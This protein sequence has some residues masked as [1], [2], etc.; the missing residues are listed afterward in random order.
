MKHLIEIPLANDETVIVE[1]DGAE[2][3]AQPI[4]TRRGVREFVEEQIVER[5]GQ[6][7]EAALD[8]VRPAAAAIIEKLQDLSRAP[9]E[10]G[11]E[12]GIKF[13]AKGNAFIT[14]ADT[15]A[16]FKVTLKWRANK[17]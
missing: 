3:S 9:S 15:E 10:I 5:A 6:T 13:G 14:S 17:Q 12:F 11:V 4:T 8:K 16:N 7:F 1:I 2:T